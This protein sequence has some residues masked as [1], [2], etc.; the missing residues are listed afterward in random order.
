[1]PR[2]ESPPARAVLHDRVARLRQFVFR[3]SLEGEGKDHPLYSVR[4]G[5]GM[6]IILDARPHSDLDWEIPKE[7]AVAWEFHLGLD[8]P[9]FPL[10]DEMR[11]QALS[12]ALQRFTQ[13][14]WPNVQ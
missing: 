13:E 12:L 7:G 6:T 3:R 11:F 5:R 2:L 1:M 8:E 9:Y 14:I 10:E 4:E